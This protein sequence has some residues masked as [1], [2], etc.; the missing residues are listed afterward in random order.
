MIQ[1]IISSL[2]SLL[3]PSYCYHCH[4]E[5]E[6][7]CE[8]CLDARKRAVDTPAPY[9]TSVYSF[10][11]PVIKK[12]IHAVKYFHRKDLISPLTKRLVDEIKMRALTT[13]VLVPIPMPTM[14]QYIRGYNHTEAM[15]RVIAKHTNL[16]VQINI[17]TRAESKKRQVTTRSR[18][19]RLKNQHNAFKVSTDVRGLHIILIDDVTT[20]GATLL[21]ARR[22]LLKEGATHVEAFTIAH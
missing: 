4:K 14:R 10:K 13:Y 16:P 18:N 11:D 2:G 20:T 19:E 9:I 22:V 7:F 12:A 5:G 8:D 3:F 15:A 6:S 17:L 1:K 21:E